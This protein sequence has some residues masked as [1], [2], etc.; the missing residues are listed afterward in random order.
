MAALSNGS[1]TV[2]TPSQQLLP[3]P[4]AAPVAVSSSWGDERDP[5]AS[6]VLVVA[7][8]TEGLDW[9]QQ[10][11]FRPVVITKSGPP[12]PYNLNDNKGNEVTSYLHFIIKHYDDLPPRM[13]FVHGH[14][15]SWHMLVSGHSV[16]GPPPPHRPPAV[17]A[18]G[19]RGCVE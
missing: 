9:L 16:P 5:V 11:P 3:A 2:Q 18:A 14:N 19:H 6:T 13:V 4:S 12:G 15:G 10:Q 17:P 8:H 1:D 7:A